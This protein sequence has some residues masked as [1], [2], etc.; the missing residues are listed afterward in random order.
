VFDTAHV[1]FGRCRDNGRIL[2][3]MVL[4]LDKE[5]LAEGRSLDNE[6]AGSAAQKDVERL[7]GE[8]LSTGR[9]GALTVDPQYLVV[10]PQLC[11]WTSL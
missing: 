6:S 5:R 8:Q 2:A 11:K 3:K 9:V 10:E 1:S 7:L 4:L